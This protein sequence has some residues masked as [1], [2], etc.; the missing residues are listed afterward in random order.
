MKARRALTIAS[1]ADDQEVSLA[2]TSEP[3]VSRVPQKVERNRSP[4]APIALLAALVAI[5]VAVW[6]L[7]SVPDASPTAER[8]LSGDPKTRVCDAGQLVAMGVQIQTNVRIGT[9]PAA[10]EAVAANARLSMLGGG[11]YLLSQI[12]ADTPGDIADAAR[13]FGSELQVI[14]MN[15]IAGT[16]NA[17]PAQADR[18]KAAESSRNTLGELCAK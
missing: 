10:L 12:S 3:R 6:A 2:S 7:L 4:L 15:A 18:I 1:V 5:G 13:K 17:D 16:D 11:D 14:G 8:Q 9:E